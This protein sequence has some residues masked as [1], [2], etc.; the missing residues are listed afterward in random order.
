M[1]K[2][3][4]RRNSGEHSS[5]PSTGRR[6]ASGATTLRARKDIVRV[7]SRQGRPS[8]FRRIATIALVVVLALGLAGLLTATLAL[9]HYGRDLPS[10]ATLRDYEPPQTSRV[11]DRHGELIGEIFSERRTVVS[12]D[13]IPR[14]LVLCVLAAEDAS[15]YEHKGL[16]YMGI[17]R[18]ILRDIVSGRA[19]QGASTITQQVVKL[20]LLT[21]ER[22]FARKIRE[23]ILARKL[24]QEL[25]KEE[26]LHLYLN[27][28][29][30]GHGR[31]GVQEAAQ[32]YFAKDV[33][34]LT[35]AE[36][37]LIAG[38]PQAPARLSPRKNPDAARTRQLYV[39]GQ[40]SEKREK[41]WPD[42]SQADIDAARDT[43]IV[44]APPP[45]SSSEAPELLTLARR[46][47]KELVD[48][49]AF[50]RGGYTIRTAID[51]R[52]QRFAREA[53]R[54][55]LE[56]IDHRHG[57][58]GPLKAE[59]R[60]R[61]R[62]AQDENADSNEQALE[63]GAIREVLVKG[64]DDEAGHL[65]VEVDG[66]EALVPIMSS[67][68]YNPESLPP[69]QFAQ[70]GTRLKIRIARGET[71]DQRPSGTLELGPQ[72]AVVVIDPRTRDVLASVGGYDAVTGF[73]RATAARRQPGSTFKPIVY[74][75]G[76]RSR[77]FSPGSVVIDA[78]AVYDQ[79]QPNN[80]ESWRFEGAISLRRA[81]AKS[82][83]VVAVRVMEEVEPQAVVSFARQLGIQSE[84][85]ASL[86]LALGA[87]AVTPIEMANAY[88]TFAAGGRWSEPRLLLEIQD[89]KGASIPLPSREPDRDALTAAEAYLVTSMLTSVVQD[90]T[91]KSAQKL[92]RPA[93]GKTGTSNRARDAWFVGYT[94]EIVAAVWVG[95][96]DNRS[97]GRRESGGKSAL[98]I[99]I[100][101][102][103]RAV[104]G[105]PI[106]DFPRP[107]GVVTA[108]IDPASG[109]LAYEGLETAVEE[110][111]L[112]GMAPQE[113]M[114]PADL[115]DPNTFLMEQVGG[116]SP[117]APGP[118][119]PGGA[120]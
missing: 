87:S 117:A 83:N 16:D 45:E 7:R 6:S 13:A 37:S 84:L 112:E 55:G 92:H 97:L 98:P 43:N 28:I 53:L 91:A 5:R 81:L 60:S 1:P 52:V 109:L 101:T 68:R 49:E 93:A 70:V 85:E 11:V 29:N 90:G 31:Y 111:F 104:E 63:E 115:I 9:W 110:V 77:R 57:Y 51:L 23:L 33:S 102:V 58:R 46:T 65:L 74:A 18:A 69:S 50:H 41:H 82:V 14:A 26:I 30:F 35:L 95:F 76:I 24:E 79:W 17:V 66:H 56:G 48:K 73:D 103:E 38:L 8:S 100:E 15:F 118:P 59:K 19:A 86:A 27:H 107:S 40:L 32:Y 2:P 62:R 22:T 106:V 47:L 94:P 75:M 89:G 25:S 116:A 80:Y 21:P 113:A 12:T 71:E 54:K 114:R 105:K 4:S 61:R 99:W 10:V 67:T 96:D 88:A 108:R 119:A 72:G 44:L 39:L 120:P 64:H 36:A 42:L 3:P 20:L 34:E 78:P